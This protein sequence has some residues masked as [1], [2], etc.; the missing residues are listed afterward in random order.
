MT[1][2]PRGVSAA[3]ELAFGRDVD[4]AMLVKLFGAVREKEA[5]Y[6]PA[7]VK[8]LYSSLRG[9]KKLPRASDEGC[10]L[11][12]FALTAR[13]SESAIRKFAAKKPFMV[14]INDGI[15]P[16]CVLCFG[17]SHSR[18]LSEEGS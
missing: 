17:D 9:I 16:S 1:R 7:K 18:S 4:Y 12:P 5:T 10:V 6:S 14:H 13:I 15:R 11:V 8:H 3:V 2:T